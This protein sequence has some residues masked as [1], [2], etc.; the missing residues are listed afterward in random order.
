MLSGGSDWYE[1]PNCP[2]VFHRFEFE[3]VFTV[4]E[5][6]GGERNAHPFPSS[7]LTC[8]A[9]RFW[10]LPHGIGK[11]NCYHPFPPPHLFYSLSL[12]RNLASHILRL[13]DRATLHY[14][15]CGWHGNAWNACK[16]VFKP[17]YHSPTDT[18]DGHTFQ[19]SSGFTLGPEHSISFCSVLTCSIKDSYTQLCKHKQFSF[20]INRNLRTTTWRKCSIKS[21]V[22]FPDSG[23]QRAFSFRY[24]VCRR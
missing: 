1:V 5:G 20:V 14:Y 10:L 21:V 6:I 19:A 11:G 16:V 15:Y 18:G 4:A 23:V 7:L 17:H 9:C 2:H 3:R 13:L 8:F 22:N 12:S 24:S